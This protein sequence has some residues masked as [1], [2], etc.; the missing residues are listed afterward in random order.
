MAVEAFDDWVGI[1]RA[2]FPDHHRLSDLG[3]P[4]V[5]ATPE[6]VRARR[7]AYLRAHPILEMTDQDGARRVLPDLFRAMEWLDVMRAGDSLTFVHTHEGSL[8]LEGSARGPL[9][10]RRTEPGGRVIAH[11]P[12]LSVESVRVIIWRYLEGDIGACDREIAGGSTDVVTSAYP[13]F[14]Q[15]SR[16][17]RNDLWGERER[18]VALAAEPPNDQMQRTG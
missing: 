7:Q 16:A 18:L 4:F 8:R 10:V 13:H 1:L 12:E 14:L 2:N 15:A 3:G 5:P 9:S 6:E 17:C 11:H